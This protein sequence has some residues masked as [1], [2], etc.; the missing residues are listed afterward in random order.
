MSFFHL[1]TLACNYHLTLYLSSFITKKKKLSSRVLWVLKSN[2]RYTSYIF[3]AFSRIW[4]FSIIRKCVFQG[5]IVIAQRYWSFYSQNL[6]FGVELTEKRCNI[7]CILKD[8]N[9][10]KLFCYRE[11]KLFIK[12]KCVGILTLS[13]RYTTHLDLIIQRNFLICLCRDK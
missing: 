12:G 4:P 10:F 9:Q 1:K 6:L 2:Y 3:L 13:G 11:R 5:L 7:I 8:L